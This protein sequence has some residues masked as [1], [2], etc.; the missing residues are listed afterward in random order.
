MLSK[1]QSTIHEWLIDNMYWETLELCLSQIPLLPAPQS[2]TNIKASSKV[3]TPQY[4]SKSLC[5]HIIQ[6]HLIN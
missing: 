2:G 6:K 3:F 1:N 5:L 4:V